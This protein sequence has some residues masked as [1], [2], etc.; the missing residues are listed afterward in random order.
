MHLLQEKQSA[1]PTSTKEQKFSPTFF[2]GYY[3]CKTYMADILYQNSINLKTDEAMPNW[4][5]TSYVFVGSK[6]EITDLY[7]KMRSLDEAK[8]PL[9]QSDFGT[10]WLGNVVHLYGGDREKINC[11]G[12]FQNLQLDNDTQLSF[13]TETA[14]RD[15]KEVWE[16]IRSKYNTIIYYYYAEEPANSYYFSN[17][18]S[19]LYFPERFIMES[20]ECDTEYC[21]DIEETLRIVSERLGKT[22]TTKQEMEEALEAYNQTCGDDDYLY[23]NQIQVFRE[24][25]SEC[26][27][28]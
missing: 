13:S 22:I 26:N 15:M 1:K 7:G 6:E 17:D 9:L 16:F 12:S 14:W 11:R 3:E 4:C 20:G 23:V 27:N 24:N 21:D 25:K 5:F 10:G 28:Q 19:C 2:I 18:V 8:E